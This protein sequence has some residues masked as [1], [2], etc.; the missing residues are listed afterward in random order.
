MSRE[1]GR[2]GILFANNFDFSLIIE[3]I[4]CDVMNFFGSTADILLRN[5][6]SKLK[7]ENTTF[8][9]REGD[10][11]STDKFLIKDTTEK[12]CRCEM[13]ISFDQ[14]PT[15]FKMSVKFLYSHLDGPNAIFF[16]YG[17]GFR[18]YNYLDV[19]ATFID[20]ETHFETEKF[21]IIYDKKTKT[22]TYHEYH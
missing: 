15:I 13:Y 5:L 17:G 11:F 8:S 3:R 9:Y 1:L 19:I 18:I 7:D 4:E 22:K 12:K 2:E 16:P 14:L 6:I 20:K 21:E 10:K